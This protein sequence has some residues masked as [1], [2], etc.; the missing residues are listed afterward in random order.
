M[1]ARV[2]SVGENITD[3]TR[4]QALEDCTESYIAVQKASEEL[5][6]IRSEHSS[7]LKRWKQN[8][9]TIE[10]LKRAIKDRMLDPDEVIREEHEYCRF[11]ALQNMPTIQQDLMALWAQP[12]DV[13]QARQDEIQ[14]NRWRDD[15][16]LA[17]RNGVDRA[18]NPHE[19]GS[20]AHQCWDLG[21][22][23]SP[24]RIAKEM[25]ENPAAAV[26]DTSRAR[27]SS[28]RRVTKTTDEQIA[29]E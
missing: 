15:G 2:R 14:R 11:R 22:L 23:H 18:A 17:G 24:E 25:K 13:D 9:I 27:P 28:R 10:S 19:Q 8:G 21:W 26:V 1:V 3:E 12:M 7:R 20:E 4:L 6:T 16:A 29:A 5:K